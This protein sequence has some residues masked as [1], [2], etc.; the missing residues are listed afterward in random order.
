M[1]GAFL[2]KEDKDTFD[3]YTKE[4]IYEAYLIEFKERE[5]LNKEVNRLG[6]KLAEIKFMAGGR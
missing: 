3:K 5:R 6:R 1:T 2:T 4:Q